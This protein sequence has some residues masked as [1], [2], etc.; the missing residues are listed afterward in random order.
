MRLRGN[1]IRGNVIREMRFG[2]IK[3]GEFIGEVA[4]SDHRSLQVAVTATKQNQSSGIKVLKT[5]FAGCDASLRSKIAQSSEMIS[6][7]DSVFLLFSTILRLF[8]SVRGVGEKRKYDMPWFCPEIRRAIEERIIIGMR[9][10]E[11]FPRT[12]SF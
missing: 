12:I 11:I 4:F 2:V 5:D 10:C 3:L 8:Q 9:D 6:N 1:E 7:F